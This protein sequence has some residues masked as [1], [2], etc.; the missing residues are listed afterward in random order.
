[1]LAVFGLL[2]LPRLRGWPGGREPGQ[3]A[4]GALGLAL[5]LAGLAHFVRP[6]LFLPMVPSFLPSPELIVLVSGIGELLVGVGLLVPR[7]RR[8]SG[9]AAVALFVAIWPGSI[10]TAISGN[11]PPGF[12]QEPL[13]HWA[14][15]PFHLLY[16]G[17][18]LWIALRCIPGRRL[19]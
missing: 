12:T 15:I 3:K 5:V 17:W 7:T 8:A 13:Y 16:V 1:M 14:R 2:H 19:R 18:A 10:Y 6:E 9:W 11:Y 4:A